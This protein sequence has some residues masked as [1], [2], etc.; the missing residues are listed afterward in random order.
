MS[1]LE[2][3]SI[4][5]TPFP[6]TFVG[7]RSDELAS[8]IR[9]KYFSKLANFVRGYPRIL[10]QILSNFLLSCTPLQP[11]LVDRAILSRPT[12]PFWSFIDWTEIELCLLDGSLDNPGTASPSTRALPSDL[13]CYCIT[14]TDKLNSHFHHYET[15]F[16]FC[17]G[18]VKTEAKTYLR[19]KARS[20]NNQLWLLE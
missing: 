14:E 20:Y 18:L 4:L 6:L 7:R 17:S 5:Y 9:Q 13:N 2:E 16:G 3:N 19:I 15:E 12:A 10:W 1:I 11:N 8:Q